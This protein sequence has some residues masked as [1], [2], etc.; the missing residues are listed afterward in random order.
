[1]GAGALWLQDVV[2]PAVEEAAGEDPALVL[3]EV[4]CRYLVG[5]AEFIGNREQ[6]AEQAKPLNSGP[7]AR[8]WR[9]IVV[10][11]ELAGPE[12]AQKL[13]SELQEKIQS[14]HSHLSKRQQEVERALN[15][16][17]RDY[18]SGKLAGPSLDDEQRE[19]LHDELGWFGQLALAPAGD[20]NREAREAVLQAA[21]RTAV[22]ILAAVLL[23]GILALAG[24]IAV[25]ALVI[26]FASGQLE[27]GLGLNV[28]ASGIY[29]ETFALWLAFFL[30][31]NIGLAFLPLPD[32][33]IAAAGVA[34]LLSLSA[35]LWPVL[36]GVAWAQ[37]CKDVGLTSGRAGPFEPFFGVACYSMTLPILAIGLAMTLVLIGLTSD[38]GP[39]GDSGGF[40]A[41]SVPAHPIILY[42]ARA[43]W[44][45]RLQV[46]VV[47]S[48]TAPI[49]EE[50]MFRGVLY[51]HLRSATIRLGGAMS[52]VVSAVIVSFLFA[53][54]HPQGLLAV[55]AL[56][57]LAGGLTL[58]REWRGSLV[59]GMFM[60]AMNNG[61][62][63]LVFMLAIS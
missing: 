15:L 24:C 3:E 13:L 46:L 41:G 28:N 22:V 36:R 32:M 38:G 5:A 20:A 37:V 26:L 44:W 16:L 11:G 39:L 59:A 10:M 56:M 23:V 58:T 47:A 19:L 53:I 4:Q 25:L 48:L 17:Y 8:R 60:H 14:S 51:G 29:A 7:L 62:L 40:E 50:T 30:A 12:E 57:A 34:S 42:I 6:L 35:L 61:I 27:G 1:L 52:I 43:G 21:R 31:L 45:S 2:R 63:L 33:R 9:S 54:V 18:V 55:P 49:V